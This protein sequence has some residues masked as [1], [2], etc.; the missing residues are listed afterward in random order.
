MNLSRRRGRLFGSSSKSRCFALSSS[1]AVYD[2]DDDKCYDY[3]DNDEPDKAG[4]PVAVALAIFHNLQR[5][6]VFRG[7]QLS[8]EVLQI[9]DEREL[10]KHGCARQSKRLLL[11]HVRTIPDPSVRSDFAELLARHA[12]QGDFSQLSLRL[13]VCRDTCLQVPLLAAFANA[14][15]RHSVE[16]VTLQINSKEK[17]GGVVATLDEKQFSPRLL[18][19]LLRKLVQVPRSELFVSVECDGS[20][21]GDLA[22]M[23]I[24]RALRSCRNDISPSCEVRVVVH[25]DIFRTSEISE[26]LASCCNVVHCL[27]LPTAS[28]FSFKSL[29]SLLRSTSLSS[30]S[31]LRDLSVFSVEKDEQDVELFCTS[32]ADCLYSPTT[33]LEC[34][35]FYEGAPLNKCVMSGH[36]EQALEC[37]RFSSKNFHRG[38][39]LQRLRFDALG[40]SSKFWRTFGKKVLP[41]LKVK[42]LSIYHVEWS[43]YSREFISRGLQQ[44]QYIQ[45]LELV[46]LRGDRAGY[47]RR[48]QQLIERC[49][50]RNRCMNQ[51][52]DIVKTA[53]ENKHDPL[54]LLL[55]KL[56]E[57]NST[58]TRPRLRTPSRSDREIENSTF[59]FTYHLVR[60]AM[61]VYLVSLGS[62]T[63]SPKRASYRR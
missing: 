62:S 6:G 61:A 27:R 15:E 46:Y 29:S 50:C 22:C 23:D 26:S 4:F 41:H 7:G 34:L 47:F 21:S 32:L 51:I 28:R 57:L 8:R 10:I 12:K 25:H 54:Q 43:K 16:Q 5:T 36:L 38:K 35:D 42:C 45:E 58:G 1:L 44:N 13:E 9:L 20:S 11:G 19:Q 48:D 59:T 53:Y 33:S 37:V 18:T 31:S 56:T 2:T 24:F 60:D 52:W 49:L 3:Y 30:N 63:S 14:F 40:L 17:P 39:C 55:D